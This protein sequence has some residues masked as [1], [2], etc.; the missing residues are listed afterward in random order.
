MAGACRNPAVALAEEDKE[1]EAMTLHQ[2]LIAGEWVG[3]DGVANV[4]P[5][6]TNDVVGDYARA[7]A[8]DA[9][10]AIAAAKAAFPTWSRSGILER[11]AILKKT[12]D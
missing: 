1:A 9:K 5:S 11:H 7:S 8:E 2:N 6:N 12:A 10:A 3:E 4:N